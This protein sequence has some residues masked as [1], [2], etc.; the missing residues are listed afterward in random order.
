MATAGSP[1]AAARPG[2]GEPAAAPGA[3][4]KI[5]SIGGGKGGI[6]K[7]FLAASVA[8]QLA[9]M[10]WRVVLVDADL[11]GAN[12]HNYLGLTPPS[13]TLGDFIQRRVA[14]IGDVLAETPVP[15]LRLVSG[16]G[17]LL[18]AA[19][20]GQQQ[21]LRLLRQ[22]RSVDADVVLIDIGAGVSHNV[23]DFFLLSDVP[24]LVVVPEHASVESGYRF[25][26]SAL[27]RRLR[28][29]AATDAV[30][31]LVD[32]ALDPRG[33][34]GIRTPEELL[35]RVEAEDV[36]AAWALRS[37]LA[38]FLPRLIVNE[39]RDEA[40]VAVGHQLVA[41]CTRHLDLPASYVGFVH[42]DD[43]VWQAVRHRQPF[44]SEAPGSRAAREIGEI[45]LRLA[46]G[47]ALDHGF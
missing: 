29:A 39:V 20:I 16:A 22:V 40:E 9:R 3:R 10:G 26:K 37:E 23:L 19:N 15:G 28:A 47:E 7:S 11:G 36:E 30:R 17:D 14:S 5:W 35:A 8:S 27:Y 42:H 34:L 4:R 13:R 32:S 33:P 12:L 31:A 43:A 44:L 45:A 21:R 41:A 6:G 38:A 25:V 24:I 1:A 18:S 2:H 46:W